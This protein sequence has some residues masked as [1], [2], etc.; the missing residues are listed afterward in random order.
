M[1]GPALLL[2]LRRNWRSFRTTWAR[3]SAILVLLTIGLGVVVGLLT[4]ATATL[5]GIDEGARSGGLAD[6]TVI[7]EVPL[8]PGQLADAEAVGATILPTPYVDVPGRSA[9]EDTTVRA[10]RSDQAVSRATVDAGTLPTGPDQV[11]VEKL[12]A[13]ALGL[14]VGDQVTVSGRVLRISGV[15]S[16]PDYTLASPQLGQTSDP[17]RFALMVVTPATFEA[18][19]AQHPDQAVSAY[20]YVLHGASADKLR[21]HLQRVTLDPALAHNSYVARAV[22]AARGAG[23]PLSYPAMSLFLPADDNPRITGAISDARTTMNVTLVTTILVMVLVAYVLGEFSRDRILRDSVVI[24]TQSALGTSESALLRYYLALPL[25]VTVLGSLLGTVLGRGL[26]PNLDIITGYYSFPAVPVEP[27]ALIVATG[28]GVPLAVVAL[29][30]VFVVRT[31]LHR[32]TQELLRPQ[33]TAGP[34]LPLRLE[35]MP[36]VPM[37]RLR[38]AMRTL[39]SYL[40]IVAGLFLCILLMVFGL[41]MRSSMDTYL[42]RAE[43]DISFHDYYTLRFPD[44]SGVP[45]GAH[46]AVAVPL[47]V[48]QDG[49]PGKTLTVL[50]VPPDS[51]YFP[52]DVAGLGPN[53]LVLSRAAAH[54]YRLGVGDTIALSDGSLN[55]AFRIVGIA[56]YTTSAFGFTTPANAQSLLDPAIP[57]ASERMTTAAGGKAVPYYNALFSDHPLDL[58]PDRVLT[59]STRD[60]MLAGVAKFNALLTRIVAL[61]TWSSMLIMVVV[62]YVLIRMVVAR[63]RYSISLLKALGYTDREVGRLYLDNYLWLVVGS[64]ALAIPVSVGIMSQVW[65]LMTAHLPI[66]IPFLLSVR[67]VAVMVGLALGAYAVVRV[68]TSHDTRSVPVTEVLKF[69]E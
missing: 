33:V 34:S 55:W 52:A 60:E 1:N 44:L 25:A 22:A 39:G 36:F 42:A 5:R 17:E 49:G 50:G 61:V 14:R 15:G 13:A 67:D 6:G 30:N 64:V 51:R 43:T 4:S 29:V 16:L 62:L 31:A 32:P 10:F 59:H 46:Q 3:W 45:A 41:G 12:H 65:R 7:T 69:R 21:E 37:F 53:Q 35:R 66:G 28:I 19:A 47:Q 58:D 40:L 63:Q 23:L 56:D 48:L 8:T 20:G 57:V 11:L 9:G 68:V 27:S 38:Q 2:T 54:K 24:G 26:A 18:L